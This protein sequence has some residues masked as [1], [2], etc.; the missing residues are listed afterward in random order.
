MKLGCGFGHWTLYLISS[1][2]FGW[3]ADTKCV[4]NK[5][6]N[7]FPDQTTFISEHIRRVSATKT[8]IRG[9]YT[10]CHG[11]RKGDDAD[12]ALM[13]DQSTVPV[14]LP[15]R[16]TYRSRALS[17]P[18]G[19]ERY[20]HLRAVESEDGMT[21]VVD[22]GFPPRSLRVTRLLAFG[23]CEGYDKSPDWPGSVRPH[24]CAHLMVR[25]ILEDEE[26]LHGP[27]CLL[28]L[29]HPIVS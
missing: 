12:S 7:P 29:G 21:F 25:R 17:S 8:E 3:W 2:L 4:G 1:A 20:Y 6:D 9:R 24:R 14:R 26:T 10:P 13:M 22:D 15:S 5:H 28:D 27:C 18:Y 23:T 11:I 16:L 19:R